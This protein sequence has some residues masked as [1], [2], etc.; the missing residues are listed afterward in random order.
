MRLHDKNSSWWFN[1]VFE[2]LP[3]LGNEYFR[4][5]WVQKQL[6]SLPAGESVLDAGAGECRYKKH[7]N[8]LQYTSQ[9][10]G[11]YGGEGDG[12]G[13]QIRE[14]DTSRIDIMGDITNIPVED[15]TFD[16]ILCTEVLEHLPHPEKAIKEFARILKN[17]GRLILTAPFCS[18]T[19]F[20]PFHF[21][22]GFNIYWYREILKKYG[23]EIVEYQTNG[24]Y[25]DFLG[26]ELLRV[27]LV[28][29]KYSFL[30]YL[31]FVLYLVAVPLV[32]ILAAMSK[33]SRNSE[34]QLCF[35]YHILATKATL[36]WKK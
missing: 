24:N 30:S 32:L 3:F 27:P 29:K 5:I 34:T 4:G 7:C 16:N 28:I 15:K 21:C 9:D 26:Q 10:F 12:V 35:G 22:T 8:H 17:K 19:H 23:F 33:F 2:T 6:R 20:A 18:Q 31:G 1:F 14:W 36:K 13:L 11:K 25:F